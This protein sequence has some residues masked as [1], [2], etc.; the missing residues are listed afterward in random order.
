M[1][2]SEAALSFIQHVW[3]EGDLEQIPTYVAPDYTIE[4]V[5]VGHDWVR[6]NV[7]MFRNA[8]SDL[9]LTVERMVA[10]GAVVALM[11]RLD[12]RHT[13]TMKGFAATGRLV[14]YR[15]AQFLECDP[16]TGLIRSGDYVADTLMP[17][18][19]LGIASPDLWHGPGA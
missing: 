8:F 17:R 2:P 6:D 12:G 14:S 18:I 10:S 13:G 7:I 16:E 5:V 4:G 9:V 19:Q 3:N 11:V 1:T 15:E